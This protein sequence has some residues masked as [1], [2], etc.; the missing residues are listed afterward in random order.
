MDP[1]YAFASYPTQT[2]KTSTILCLADSNLEIAFARV[3]TYQA[4]AMVSFAKWV[5][6]T[7][8]EINALLKQASAGPQPAVALLQHIAD[9]R[10]PFVF[11]ALAWLLKLGVLKVQG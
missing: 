9:A 7:E 6:P 3:Q 1:F 10:K 11:R 4:M 8:A 2:L 5:I